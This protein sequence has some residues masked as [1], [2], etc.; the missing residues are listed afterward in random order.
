MVS[1]RLADLRAAAAA[2]RRV[3]PDHDDS[4]DETA[5]RAGDTDAWMRL[6]A[7]TEAWAAE[8]LDWAHAA[9][10]ATAET[11]P[12]WDQGTTSPQPPDERPAETP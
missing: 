8:S 11:W 3:M 9:F 12:Q 10:N 2:R 6:Q 1:D 7:D 4:P 5:E